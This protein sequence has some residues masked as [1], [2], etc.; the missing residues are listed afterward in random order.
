MSAMPRRACTHLLR[1]VRI[2]TSDS[3]LGR[4]VPFVVFQNLRRR[5][6]MQKKLIALAVAGLVSGG[7]F[8]QSNVSIYGIVDAGYLNE[9]FD[10]A[11]KATSKIDSGL[12]STSRLG[13]KGEEAL[14]NG[15]KAV[16]NLEYALA[17][18]KNSTIGGNDV[19]GIPTAR[20]QSVGLSHAT[21]GTVLA[22]YLQ[23]AGYDFA[24]AAS[25]LAASAIGAGK[26]LAFKGE[27]ADASLLNYTGG[28]LE[29]ALSYVSPTFAGFNVVLNHG[30]ITEAANTNNTAD[31]YA[32]AIGINYANGPLTAGF[33]YAKMFLAGKGQPA[34]VTG[35]QT[36]IEE[37]GIRGGYD[38]G[39]AKLQAA[40]QTFEAK[41]MA[42]GRDSKWVIGATVPVSAAG[43]VVAEYASL[44]VKTPTAANNGGL[45]VNN[46]NT[47]PLAAYADAKAWT[48]AY[49]H[50]LSKRTTA[51]AGYNQVSSD[52]IN[53]ANTGD[54]KRV[55]F[56]VRHAF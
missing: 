27:A 50:A 22:G 4:V 46:F 25:P 12:L 5:S 35:S 33:A 6:T 26:V 37:Y 52:A 34:P 21:Y 43:A 13:F 41:D 19:N 53:T 3:T 47:G 15:L 1:F 9:N 20:Q 17:I 30:R 8:A 29:N 51:Y 39:V 55:A 54:V 7:A 16:F 11:D 14:G 45:T 24:V 10:G 2:K 23:S 31:Q 28:R 18:D 38:F 48:L 56:G 40:Y 44:N 42:L 36:D 32:N 49:T